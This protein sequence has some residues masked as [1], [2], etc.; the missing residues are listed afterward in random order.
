MSDFSRTAYSRMSKINVT[1][2]SFIWEQG[3]DD[4]DGE[5]VWERLTEQE[6]GNAFAWPIV[7]PHFVGT[8]QAIEII[9][10]Q[11]FTLLRN[12]AFDRLALC[13]DAGGM[14]LSWEICWAYVSLGCLPPLELGLRLSVDGGYLNA[15]QRRRV[16][17]AV[18]AGG[19][20][21]R[22]NLGW[23]LKLFNDRHAPKK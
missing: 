6:S 9:G 21:Y 4:F 22:R 3:N 5:P 11:P 18:R 10:K 13:L 19:H 23:N 20:W 2:E 14:D 1:A 17:G 12:Q 7:L 8:E 16:V 15:T